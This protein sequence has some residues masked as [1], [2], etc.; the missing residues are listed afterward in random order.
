[1]LYG[2]A[3]LNL[4]AAIAVPEGSLL[5]GMLELLAYYINFYFCLFIS[6]GTL[7]IEGFLIGCMLILRFLQAGG[8]NLDSD[9]VPSVP[10]DY[11]YST[12]SVATVGHNIP[13]AGLDGTQTKSLAGAPGAP[14]FKCTLDR[15]VD[16]I[17]RNDIP[18]VIPQVSGPTLLQMRYEQYGEKVDTS[19]EDKRRWIM[20][21]PRLYCGDAPFS[22]NLR[23][24]V[25]ATT[26]VE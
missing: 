22:I 15:L 2:A 11:L 7:L 6:G 4:K 21:R 12:C 16:N 23:G 14:I 17:K 10:L 25:S 19:E 24:C 26:A 13:H 1:M 3:L 18:S 8:V 9:I 5:L 20:G